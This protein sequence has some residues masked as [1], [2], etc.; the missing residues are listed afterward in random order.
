MNRGATR[1][2]LV[3]LALTAP[4]A[5]CSEELT[6][7]GQCP[8]LCPGG[9]L[10]VISAERNKLKWLITCGAVV[11]RRRTTLSSGIISPV[12]ERAYSCF[13]SV[14]LARNR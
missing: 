10:P 3:L 8:E 4:L 12:A 14:G 11:S 2:L 13:R 5:G 9:E 1:R 6:Q 7:P